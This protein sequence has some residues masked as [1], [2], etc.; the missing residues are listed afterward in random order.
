MNIKPSTLLL[1]VGGLLLYSQLQAQKKYA[2]PTQENFNNFPPP[3]PPGENQSTWQNW[4]ALALNTFGDIAELWGPGGPF[5][6][7]ED[8]W[9]FQQGWENLGTYGWTP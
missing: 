6:N 5:Y 3:P 9:E 2:P 1:A 8:T 4:I 7:V